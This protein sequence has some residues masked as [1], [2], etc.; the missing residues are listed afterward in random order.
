MHH[1]R[2]ALQVMVHPTYV[3]YAQLYTQHAWQA[4]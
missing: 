4:P 2:S 3:M 1:S